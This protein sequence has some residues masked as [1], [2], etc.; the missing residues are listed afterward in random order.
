MRFTISVL[1]RRCCHYYMRHRLGISGQTAATPNSL[2]VEDIVGLV[3]NG[4]SEELIITQIRKHGK[5]FDLSSDEL[6]ELRKLGVSDNIVRY[7]LD[8]SF[9]TRPLQ[10]PRLPPAAPAAAVKPPGP[11][12]IYPPDKY[13]NRVPPEP[14]IYYFG[15]AAQPLKLDA[16]V[17]L[18]FRQGAGVSKVLGKKARKLAYLPGP[19]AR[20][21]N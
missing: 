3:K 4:F 12:K 11:A 14:G 10:P 15:D 7:L 2:S 18:G 5:A 9:H 21:E 16:K 6:I 17:L 1:P 8:P 13:A 19:D 20:L